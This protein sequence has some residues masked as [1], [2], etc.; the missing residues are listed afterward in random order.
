MIIAIRDINAKQKQFLARLE[1]ESAL[2]SLGTVSYCIGNIL[3]G[4]R[5]IKE[6]KIGMNVRNVSFSILIC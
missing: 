1:A 6:E 2:I 3:P 5:E 4:E